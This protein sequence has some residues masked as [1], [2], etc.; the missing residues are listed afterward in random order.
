MQ[1]VIFSTE[2]NK[3]DQSG[4][5]RGG[6]DISYFKNQ[7]NREGTNRNYYS[8]TF[9]YTFSHSDDVVYFAHCFPYTLSKLNGFLTEQCSH[10]VK[11]RFQIFNNLFSSEQ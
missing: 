9:T 6:S 4:W 2:Q 8:L 5:F 1:P 3:K 7:I 10:P 11:K